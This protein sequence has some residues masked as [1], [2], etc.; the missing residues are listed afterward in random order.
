MKKLSL[1]RSFQP[2]GKPMAAPNKVFGR[3]FFKKLAGSRDSIPCRAP[4]SAESLSVQRAP[5]GVNCRAAA[6]RGKF[7]QAKLCPA[8]EGVP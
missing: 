5:Q 8:I 1:R 3:A 4:Q 7:R 6:M 2:V